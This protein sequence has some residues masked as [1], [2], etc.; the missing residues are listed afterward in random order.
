[1][2]EA[3]DENDK[4]PEITEQKVI[5]R[6]YTPHK[7]YTKIISQHSKNETKISSITKEKIVNIN[8][9]VD[10]KLE[11]VA[12]LNEGRLF[13]RHGAYKKKTYFRCY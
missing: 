4:N 7:I 1:L 6:K 8:L 9:V 5:K 10:A 3:E 2:Q 13:R 12:V 11:V